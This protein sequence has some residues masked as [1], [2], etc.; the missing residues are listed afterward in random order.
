MQDH[1]RRK[2]TSLFLHDLENER[3]LEFLAFPFGFDYTEF[4]QPKLTWSR[5][6]CSIFISTKT[7]INPR[8]VWASF[9]ERPSEGLIAL[10]HG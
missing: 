6:S 2:L 9:K 3:T 5:L 4:K 10:G 1:T 8:S 7:K